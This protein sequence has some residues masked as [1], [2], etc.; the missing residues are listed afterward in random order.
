MFYPIIDRRIGGN[1]RR[2]GSA[3]RR[4]TLSEV[5]VNIERRKVDRR[6]QEDR[7]TLQLDRKKLLENLQLPIQPQQKPLWIEMLHLG[8]M[9]LVVAIATGWITLKVNETQTE[10]AKVIAGSN[11]E[12]SILIADANRISSQLISKANLDTQNLG[13][14]ITLFTGIIDPSKQSN[15]NGEDWKD[16]ARHR[17]T[18]LEVYEDQSLPFLLQLERYYEKKNGSTSIIAKTA[19]QS[20]AK[21]LSQSQTDLTGKNFLGEKGNM[22]NIRFRSYADFNLSESKFKWVNLYSSDFSNAT[23]IGAR[24]YDADLV[25]ANFS[26]ANLKNAKFTNSDLSGVNYVGALLRGTKFIDCTNIR[27]AKFS[28]NTLVFS[29]DTMYFDKI[30]QND[31]LEMLMP[32]KT[33]L[34]EELDINPEQT[35]PIKNKWRD[36]LYKRLGLLKGSEKDKRAKLIKKLEMLSAKNADENL[37]KHSKNDPIVSTKVSTR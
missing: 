19:K 15:S 25:E 21:I 22:L 24:F 26:G 2:Q 30:N 23:L 10:S 9:P 16:P 3:N 36:R 1:D 37:E 31:F 5:E 7:R 20:I 4:T 14:I 28:F 6:L 32:H 18:A 27:K 17:I 8:V 34:K 35:N 12:S 11:R 29:S 33:K 13:H